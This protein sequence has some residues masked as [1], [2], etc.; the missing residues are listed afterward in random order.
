MTDRLWVF[1]A[2]F[3]LLLAFTFFERPLMWGIVLCA[4]W[5]LRIVFL[6]H[7]KILLLTIIIG[8]LFVSVL[9]FHEKQNKTFLEAGKTTLLVQ[10][11]LTSVKV[12]GDRIRFE[13][14]VLKQQEKIVIGYYAQSEAEKNM[15]LYEP[16]EDLLILKGE[17]KVPAPQ[18][19]FYQFDYQ[20]YLKRRGI[21]WQFTVD[22]IE[23]EPGIIEPKT[24]G[25]QLD[26]LRFKLLGAIDRTFMPQVA[27]YIKTL[28]FADRR[29]MPEDI[30]ANYRAIGII[31]LLSISGF[32]I[33]FLISFFKHILLR[34]GITHER[35]NIILL[36]VVPFYGLLTGLGISVFRA[37]TQAT[38]QIIRQ[39]AGKN[40]ES[41]DA[42]SLTMLLALFINPYQIYDIAFQL[43]YSLSGLLIVLREQ[44]WLRNLKPFVATLLF[45]ILVNLASLPILS[46]HFYEISWITPLANFVFIPIFTVV[47]FP[48]LILLLLSAPIIN[49]SSAFT[50][51][52]KIMTLL[53]QALES[54]PAL[55]NDS[56]SL[57]LI[58]GKLPPVFIIALIVGVFYFLK[59][60]EAKKRPSLLTISCLILCVS[61]HQI[62]PVGYVIVL[63]IGQGDAI[64]IKDPTTQKVSLIDTGGRA[65]W[66]KKDS[67][68]QQGNSFSIGQDII[69]PALKAFGISSIDYLYLSHADI[70]HSGE[71]LSI[72]EEIPIKKIIATEK[73]FKE[74]SIYRQIKQLKQTD[75]QVAKPPMLLSAPFSETVIIHPQ[76]EYENH[77][78]H[79]LV[80]YGKIGGDAWLF[81]GD[82]EAEVENELIT[83]YPNLAIDYLKVSHHGSNSSTTEAFIKHIQPHTALISAGKNNT[84]GHPHP[85]ILHT[86]AQENI[87]VYQT[88]Q[89]GA[90]RVRYVKLPFVDQWYKKLDTVYID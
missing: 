72:G 49:G 48:A 17:L 56:A 22:S 80:I 69:V 58:L 55:I 13:G 14:N 18:S 6:K 81:T 20:D 53:I 4:I 9:F 74:E 42:W 64:L 2:L 16:P 45:S 47:L 73:T 39:L 75:L 12:D 1:P 79:S 82:I 24:I 60:I 88:N 71:I 11:D 59:A 40:S 15:W 65:Q 67:W 41:I 63:D 85:D 19:N 83:A 21:H 23:Y 37:V 27:S 3:C 70:D 77:N 7:R 32:H 61:Y 44:A 31:H 10:T 5:L 62:T 25:G 57:S 34:I 30:L 29:S 54:L 68:Q 50:L 52:N 43:S 46:Y 28:F 35:T 78:N 66:H 86:L 84:Y 90:I 8:G 26:N 51:L 33:S 89:V 38:I 87:Q 36:L 76:V